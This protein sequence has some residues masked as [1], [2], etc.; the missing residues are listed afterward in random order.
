MSAHIFI[1]QSRWSLS[2]FVKTSITYGSVCYYSNED[3]TKHYKHGLSHPLPG[4]RGCLYGQKSPK[5]V[6]SVEPK[7]P[8][9]YREYSMAQ[10]VGGSG[11]KWTQDKILHLPIHTQWDLTKAGWLIYFFFQLSYY[12]TYSVF[13]LLY[14]F[15]SH[16]GFTP[17]WLMTLL[18]EWVRKTIQSC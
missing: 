6:D 4:G 11:E 1:W 12:Y 18:Q 3:L 5:A 14:S 17:F 2:H 9:S 8:N 13:R 10:R 16:L 15:A 7:T